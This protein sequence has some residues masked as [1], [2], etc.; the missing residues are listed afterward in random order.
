LLA[1]ATFLS[2]P[3]VAPTPQP[4][5]TT[6]ATLTWEEWAS[7][8]LGIATNTATITAPSDSMGTSG[9]RVSIW[10]RLTAEKPGPWGSKAFYVLLAI[11][12]VVLLGILVGSTVDLLRDRSN[13]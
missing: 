3:T 4:A 6:V 12:Y 10:E 1:Q 11:L 9:I 5:P 8:I 2:Q 7:S 13:P